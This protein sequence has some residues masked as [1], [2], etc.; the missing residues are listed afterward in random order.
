M[1]SPGDCLYI[2]SGC[3]HTAE[4]MEEESISISAGVRVPTMIDALSLVLADLASESE[5]R[6][7]LPAMGRASPLSEQERQDAW[8]R[9]FS[10]LGHTLE[11][12]L[13]TRDLPQRLF[14]RSGWWREH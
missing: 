9:R 4:A 1:L 7:R 8:R 11:A 14:A 13:A 12:R 6:Q 5:W 10:E 3:W 2:P